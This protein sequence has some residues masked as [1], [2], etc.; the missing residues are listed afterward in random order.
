MRG[1]LKSEPRDD[2]MRAIQLLGTG[3]WLGS[4]ALLIVFLWFNPYSSSGLTVGSA[5]VVTIMIALGVLG[6]YG[7]WTRRPGLLYL[8]V[9]LSFCPVGFYFLLTPGIFRA[10]GILNLLALLA[11]ILLHRRVRT[12]TEDAQGGRRYSARSPANRGE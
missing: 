9:V 12:G 6:V 11:A 2:S 5:V 8:V 10:I 1:L 7:M 4:I 3:A